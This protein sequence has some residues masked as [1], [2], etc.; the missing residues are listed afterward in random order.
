MTSNSSSDLNE[1]FDAN[2][3][4]I[5]DELFEFLRIPSVSAKS[6][7]DKDVARAAEWLRNSIVNAGMR[8][9][10]GSVDREIDVRL[11]IPVLVQH[12]DRVVCEHLEIE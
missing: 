4:R 2:D 7:N 3:S 5:R 6:E 11:E 8:V 10:E 12:H 1:F 9:V